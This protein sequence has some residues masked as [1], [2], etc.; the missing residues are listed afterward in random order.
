MYFG[1]C[2]CGAVKIEIKSDLSL[3]VHCYCSMC[4]KAHG[5]DH[6][7]WGICKK[8]DIQIVADPGIISQYESSA[9]VFRH[10]CSRCGSNIQWEDQSEHS[11]A[12]VSFALRLLEQPPLTVKLIEYFRT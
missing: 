10:F 8:T 12:H 5:S 2:L 3:L 6:S 7:E 9:G 4:Q 11:K 1:K